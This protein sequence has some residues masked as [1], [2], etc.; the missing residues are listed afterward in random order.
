MMRWM[1]ALLVLAG[2][3][4]GDV[5]NNNPDATVSR[6]EMQIG[7]SPSSPEIGVTIDLDGSIFKDGVSGQDTF[8]WRVYPPTGSVTLME[9]D[10][11]D[12]SKWSF[13]PAVAGPHQIEL[14]GE[15]GGLSCTD[16][17]ISIN[18]LT[19]GAATKRYRF[20]FI[21]AAGDNAPIQERSYEIPGGAAF[22]L[23]TIGLDG[24]VPITGIV[25]DSGAVP[26][27]A[28][29]RFT[30]VGGDGTPVEAF[31]DQT[32]T[33]VARL[34]SAAYDVLVVP[35]DPNASGALFPNR[36]SGTL[37]DLTL[38]VAATVSGTVLDGGGQPIA[39][40]QVS[41]RVGGVPSSLGTTDATGS[42][43]VKAVTGAATALTVTPPDGSGLPR[44]ELPPGAGLI[45]ASASPL[46]I[47]YSASLTSRALGFGV[48]DTD[49]TT[50]LPGAGV[51]L[52]MRSIANAGT[53]TPQG[54]SALAASGELRLTAT[55]DGAGDIAGL[56]VPEADYD[57]IL[58]PAGGGLVTVSTIEVTAGQPSPTAL[59]LL[60]PGTIVGRILD[61][62]QGQ[63]G[64]RVIASPRA[65]LASEAGAA[66]MASSGADGGFALPVVGDGLYDLT[67]QPLTSSLARARVIGVTAP[68]GGEMSALMDVPLERA[69]SVRGRVALPGANGSAGITVLVLCDG[70]T[71]LAATMPIA[72]DVSVAGG[73]FDV[74]IPDPQNEATP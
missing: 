40:A 41:L 57:V 27:A 39:G 4:G 55:A 64:I 8:D 3:G 68:A 24:G 67:L 22:D 58:R 34:S 44:L 33:Y 14:R 65:L 32:G 23:Q 17:L 53:V 20:R 10:P 16:E 51:T 28:Y 15:V 1:A 19:P 43:A 48:R 30:L 54:G 36:V 74:A 62:T 6:C 35:T 11:F 71:G 21:P 66:A 60:A 56:A 69:I 73:Y 31:S 61:G 59:S 38:P 18:V 42:W 63:E 45:A 50:P 25:R 49:T 70:C 47:R 5:G 72:D 7:Y 13:A 52:V 37:N 2:C 9:R 29:L 26:I 46:T 12:N